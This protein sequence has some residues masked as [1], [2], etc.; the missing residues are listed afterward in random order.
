[1]F[2]S[3]SPGHRRMTRFVLSRANMVDDRVVLAV[4]TDLGLKAD[5]EARETEA[6]MAAADAAQS[7]PPAPA[8]D[9]DK[10]LEDL[11]KE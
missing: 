1:M 3:S 11:K 2:M 7:R 9:F 6:K 4:A 10:M 5:V 8:D